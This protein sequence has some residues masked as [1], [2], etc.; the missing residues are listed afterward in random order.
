M[1]FIAVPNNLFH[2]HNKNTTLKL[3]NQFIFCLY[4]QFIFV[5]YLIFWESFAPKITVPFPQTITTFNSQDLRCLDIQDI[6]QSSVIVGRN[7]L[8][9]KTFGNL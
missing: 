7:A 4:F 9:S 3:F 1:I 6:F 8:C 5:F 2:I